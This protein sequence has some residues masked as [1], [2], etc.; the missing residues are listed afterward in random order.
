MLRNVFLLLNADGEVLK[1]F[2][3]CDGLEAHE[4]V[5]V[6]R[7]YAVATDGFYYDA[8]RGSLLFGVVDLSGSSAKFRVR[9]ISLKNA[10]VVWE[11]TLQPSVVVGDVY[12]GGYANMNKPNISFTGNKI[13]YNY[14]VES[15]VYVLDRKTNKTKVIEADSR[16]SKNVADKCLSK[17]DYTQWER[18]A[19]ENPHFYE[20]VHLPQIGKYVRLHTSECVY[21]VGKTMEELICGKELSL[22]VFNDDFSVCGEM[23]LAR[24]R[25]SYFTGWCA[26]DDGIVLYVDNPLSDE[27]V[28]ENLAVDIL[29]L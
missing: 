27:Q 28:T 17:D 24:N 3:P 15:H 21:D 10:K 16:F 5:L 8:E 2:N 9:E 7:N 23:K 29:R 22:T 11:Y 13:V 26:M 14:P 25:Y 19:I 6:G 12:S 1:A 18:H 4:S 20:V